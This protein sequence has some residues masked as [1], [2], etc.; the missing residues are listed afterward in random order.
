MSIQA[1]EIRC[2]DVTEEQAMLQQPSTAN[3]I[4]GSEPNVEGETQTDCSLPIPLIG[5]AGSSNQKRITKRLIVIIACILVCNLI[6]SASYTVVAGFLTQVSL[7]KGATHIQAGFLFSV[8]CLSYFVGTPFVGTIIM[9]VGLRFCFL[10][11]AFILGGTSLIFAFVIDAP[12]GTSFVALG[13]C[14]RI[15]GGIGNLFCKASSYTSLSMLAP[16]HLGTVSGLNTAFVGAG[17]SLGPFIGGSLYDL[18]GFKLPFFIISALMVCL[19]ILLWY[20]LPY[21]FDNREHK[22]DEAEQKRNAATEGKWTDFVDVYYSLPILYISSLAGFTVAVVNAYLDLSISNHV[23]S[24]FG[25][26]KTVAGSLFIGYQ[27]AYLL[28]SSFAGV[29]CD[30]YEI[31]IQ[32]MIFGAIVTCLSFLFLGPAPFLN[33]SEGVWATEICMIFSGVGMA[34]M[35]IP[36]FKLMIRLAT[37][38]DYPDDIKGRSKLTGFFLTASSAGGF[39]G[40]S[41]GGFLLGRFGYYWSSTIIGFF[42]LVSVFPLLSRKVYEHWRKRTTKSPYEQIS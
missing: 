26:S 23:T 33:M 4:E 20:F 42:T 9:Q 1:E 10:A 7:D 17:L 19:G 16:N 37:E 28:F 13:L 11:G 25:E 35:Y 41:V 30:K 22:D 18:G 34:L 15:V 31:D 21:D 39:T 38:Y 3:Y 32:S 29:L 36:S 6:S 12:S 14:V 5:E 27:T 8:F 40:P 24:M 2:I